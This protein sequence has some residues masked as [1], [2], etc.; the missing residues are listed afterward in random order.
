V[1]VFISPSFD[2]A[3]Q[4]EGGIRRVVEAQRAY[5]PAHGVEVVDREQ[6]ADLVAIHAGAYVQTTKPVVAHN[7]GL[8]WTPEYE[9]DS[10]AHELN[11]QV[12]NVLRRCDAA[13]APSD[14]V[15]YVIKRGM[16]ID[17]QT[18]H[19]GVD[20]DDWPPGDKSHPYVLWNK[21]RVD[22]ICDPTPV[23]ELA[24]RLPMV[25]FVTT[26]GSSDLR[27]VRV[28]GRLP[29]AQAKSLVQHATVYLATSRETFGI[30][31]LEAMAAGAI[32][33]GFDWGG[34]KE[35]LRNGVD[36]LLV[37]VGDYDALARAVQRAFDEPSG[38][39]A[40]ALA[41]VRSE[42]GWDRAMAR[43]ADVYQQTY[44]QWA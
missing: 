39:C 37:P 30:G 32:V 43:Y 18:V 26:F 7:H 13:T 20:A 34:Q 15:A 42:F 21:N 12:I 5:L 35:I 1:K 17:A 38:F 24:K 28:T 11:N 27:N 9:W 25:Q 19:H 6:D 23:T 3:D 22:P 2:H 41:R 10:W 14:W 31:T 8:Y 4:G 40:N 16:N 44:E 36:G 33:V 29:F